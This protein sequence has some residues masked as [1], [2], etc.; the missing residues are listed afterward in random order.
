MTF[1]PSAGAKLTAARRRPLGRLGERHFP[2]RVREALEELHGAVAEGMRELLSHSLKEF[3]QALFRSAEQARNNAEQTRCFE[4]IRLVRHNEGA[5]IDRLL[6]RIESDHA[7]AP[8]SPPMVEAEPADSL[9]MGLSLVEEHVLE[10]ELA[11]QEMASRATIRFSESLHLLGQRYAVLVAAPAIEAEQLPSGPDALASALGEAVAVAALPLDHRLELFRVTERQLLARLG[12]LYGKLNTVCV[13]RRILP[14]LGLTARRA[15]SGPAAQAPAAPGSQS[16]APKPEAPSEDIAQ[17][18]QSAAMPP[19][20]QSWQSQQAPPAPAYGGFQPHPGQFMPSAGNQQP[21]IGAPVPTGAPSGAFRSM[22]SPAPGEHMP[23]QTSETLAALAADLARFPGLAGLMQPVIGFPELPAPAPGDPAEELKLVDTLLELL[24]QRR[25]ALGQNVPAAASPGVTPQGIQQAL[26]NI[27]R[28]RH[29]T[30][31]AVTPTRSGIGALRDDLLV[32]LRAYS[33]AGQTPELGA[34]EQ[35]AI[36]LL[37]ML[38]GE[39]SEEHRES[40]PV[41]ELLAR[42]EVPLLRVALRDRAFFSSPAHPARRL[43][44]A[45]SMSGRFWVDEHGED[46]LLFTRLRAMVDRITRDYDDDLSVFDDL[47]EDLN[48]FLSTLS[49]KSEVAEKRHVETA[50][51]RERL[52][53]ARRSAKA[54][55][56]NLLEGRETAMIVRTLLEQTWTDVLSLTILKHGD[57]PNE[58]DRVLSTA[59]RLIQ[60]LDPRQPA[61]D[62]IAKERLTKELVAGLAQ[63]GYHDEDARLVADRLFDADRAGR[64]GAPVSLTEIAIKLKSRTRLGADVQPDDPS[65]SIEQAV[66]GKGEA[67]AP[68]AKP[69]LTEAEAAVRRHLE[70]TPFGT[71]FEFVLMGDRRSRRK[72]AWFSPMSGRC[73]FVNARGARTDEMSLD[74]LAR[75]IA[76]GDI[77]VV[78]AEAEGDVEKAWKRIT[79]SL[80]RVVGLLPAKPAPA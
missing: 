13:A 55:I 5:I 42:L 32:Q 46:T 1:N 59:N 44:N 24:G 77:S 78:R 43:L 71:W 48:G 62:E 8:W 20:P 75:R 50:R 30:R 17:A 61:I 57:D 2:R 35:D 21:S 33:P 3:D 68:P 52:E 23:L 45:I 79:N 29:A 67:E 74:D 63:I 6:A 58:L 49:R 22:P 47:L 64:D 54:A 7:A 69:A 11:M 60:A 14:N 15:G 26:A 37:G 53:G 9:S 70:Q 18:P 65:G 19:A 38:V 16:E 73:L 56:E 72:L 10:E 41:R 25:A 28:Q 51:G 39:L 31:N 76:A 12:I 27:Q 4:S 80:K 40:H 36:E 34:P 66:A